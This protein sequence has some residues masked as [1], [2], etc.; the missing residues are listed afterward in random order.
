MIIKRL[1]FLKYS[2]NHLS[3]SVQENVKLNYK[4]TLPLQ[5]QDELSTAE[6][7]VN[8]PCRLLTETRRYYGAISWHG[9]PFDR[10]TNRHPMMLLLPGWI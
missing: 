5:T 2:W 8:K 3:A 6:H 4:R 9:K 10:I 1:V 7:T